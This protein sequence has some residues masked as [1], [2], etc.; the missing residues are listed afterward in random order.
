MPLLIASF[1]F[2][3]GIQLIG[4]LTWTG[5]SLSIQ[6]M[7]LLKLQNLQTGRKPPGSTS[8]C[9]QQRSVSVFL[10]A[11]ILLYRLL[12]LQIP[13]IL[14]RDTQLRQNKHVFHLNNLLLVI[15]LGSHTRKDIGEFL[16]S[17]GADLASGQVTLS[18]LTLVTFIEGFLAIS[19]HSVLFKPGAAES[20]E[21]RFVASCLPVDQWFSNVVMCQNMMEGL[22]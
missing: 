18:S 8:L 21:P 1:A 15:C 13:R 17:L 12:F 16:F 10:K 2:C 14:E 19:C 3:L 5:S 9:L 22:S 20:S 6:R 7:V 4:I 11:L